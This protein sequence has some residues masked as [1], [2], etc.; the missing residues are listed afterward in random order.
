MFWNQ[1]LGYGL[2]LY[3]VQPGNE[4]RE[5]IS[6]DTELDWHIFNSFSIRSA[7]YISTKKKGNFLFLACYALIV[8]CILF[9]VLKAAKIL[10]QN[11]YHN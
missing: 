1:V 6:R 2:L 11:F 10:N 8:Q 9:I 3:Q 7:V 5:R 4:P